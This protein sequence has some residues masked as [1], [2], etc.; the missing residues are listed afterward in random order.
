MVNEETPEERL[1]KYKENL[2]KMAQSDDWHTIEE[3]S[4]PSIK[5]ESESSPARPP[6]VLESPAKKELRESKV[7][8]K[9]REALY[10]KLESKS[11]K[12]RIMLR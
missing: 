7:V 1:K 10:S 12:S 2:A 8:K 4:A 6:K 9:R 11:G 3:P 5:L